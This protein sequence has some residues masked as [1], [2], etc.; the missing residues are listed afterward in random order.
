METAALYTVGAALNVSCAS[1]LS[2]L[3]N[4]ERKKA[5]IIEK[6]CMDSE[7]AIMLAVE[8]IKKLIRT[9]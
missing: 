9:K 2:V 5:G 3:W 8:T 4:Q 7:L 6:D 1:I